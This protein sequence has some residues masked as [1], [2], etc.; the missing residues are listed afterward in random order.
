M[1][2]I[3]RHTLQP[4]HRINPAPGGDHQ[5]GGDLLLRQGPAGL[6]LDH[7]AHAGRHQARL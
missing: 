6:R 2:N 3:S 4:V 1:L 7:Q 5:G